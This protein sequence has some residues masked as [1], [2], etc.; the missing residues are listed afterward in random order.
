MDTLNEVGGSGPRRDA[1]D[2]KLREMETRV[3]E[4]MATGL[5][6]ADVADHLGLTVATVRE[7]VRLAI[8]RLGARSKLEAVIIAARRGLISVSLVVGSVNLSLVA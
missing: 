6:T 7:H 8:V 3:L 2:P 4:L 1:V 5:S